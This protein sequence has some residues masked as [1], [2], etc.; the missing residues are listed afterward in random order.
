MDSA[1]AA[2]VM[3]E[4]MFSRGTLEQRTVNKSETGEKIIPFKTHEAIHSFEQ[5]VGAGLTNP[6]IRNAQDR[7]S[8]EAGDEVEGEGEL[9]P[10]DW[11][12]KQTDA[13]RK[14]KNTKQH[15]CRSE[16]GAHSALWA[17]DAPTP[18]H[19]MKE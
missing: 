18:R 5:H 19:Q 8:E 7:M 14:G 13:E 4:D 6:H 15:T 3:L 2:H 10:P 1:A 16:T 11:R 17:E 12:A 9:A